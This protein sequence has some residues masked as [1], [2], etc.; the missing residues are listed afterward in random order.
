MFLRRVE[1][2]SIFGGVGCLIV[3]CVWSLVAV[4]F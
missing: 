4:G 3:G 1:G 2:D